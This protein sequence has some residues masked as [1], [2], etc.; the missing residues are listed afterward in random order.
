MAT[1]NVE[2]AHVVEIAPE[3]TNTPLEAFINSAGFI[4]DEINTK[5]GKTFTDARLFEIKR[6]LAAH[7]VSM[8]QIGRGKGPLTSRSIGHGA[9][10]T[11]FATIQLGKGVSNTT[12]GQTANMLSEGCLMKWDMKQATIT[13]GGMAQG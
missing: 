9:V 2:E 13:F 5:F 7:F 12:Y 4:V 3:L 10:A 6:F 11:T 8:S 1:L